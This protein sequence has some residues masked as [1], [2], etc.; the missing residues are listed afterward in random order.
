MPSRTGLSVRRAAAADADAPWRRSASVFSASRR[1]RRRGQ[2][3][4]GAVA[5]V[6]EPVAAFATF[7]GERAKLADEA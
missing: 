3:F 1:S 5:S 4:F 6:E 2:V 7:D